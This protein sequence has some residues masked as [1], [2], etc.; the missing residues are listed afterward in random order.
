M[1]GPFFSHERGTELWD[2]SAQPAVSDAA[3]TVL[4]RITYQ[5][6]R[7]LMPDDYF[8]CFSQ[9]PVWSDAGRHLLLTVSTQL[10]TN[11]KSTQHRTICCYCYCFCVCEPLQ[12]E[13][14]F[15]I[16]KRDDSTVLIRELWFAFDIISRCGSPIIDK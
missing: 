4:E 3:R 6:R 7:K 2:R 1:I 16:W 14:S 12:L 11:C 8:V 13:F 9:T 10:I 15:C 5:V